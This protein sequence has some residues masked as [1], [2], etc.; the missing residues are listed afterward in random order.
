MKGSKSTKPRVSK[1]MAPK[2]GGEGLSGPKPVM[3]KG[4][5]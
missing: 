4:V 3:P 5:K 2:G 1:P